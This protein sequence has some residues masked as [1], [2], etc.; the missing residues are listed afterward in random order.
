MIVELLGIVWFLVFCWDQYYHSV[1]VKIYMAKFGIFHCFL[2]LQKIVS[3]HS[4]VWCSSLLCT[5]VN[6][7]VCVCVC[8][9]EDHYMRFPHRKYWRKMTENNSLCIGMC[10]NGQ[11]DGKYG[12]IYAIKTNESYHHY[13]W[14]TFSFIDRLYSGSDR[15]RHVYASVNRSIVLTNLSHIVRR[16]DR[17]IS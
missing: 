9:G 1:A 8:A 13:E 2:L 12:F 6:A 4:S 14:R 16:N 5:A 3:T 10:R 11:C 15:L 7:R 17:N